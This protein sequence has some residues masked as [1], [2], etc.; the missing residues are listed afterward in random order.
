MNK[1]IKKL[2]IAVD[3]VH[4]FGLK[5]FSVEILPWHFS[6]KY[7]FYSMQLHSPDASTPAPSDFRLT[8]AD[9]S[10]LMQIMAARPHFYTEAQLKKRFQAGHM[11]FLGWIKTEPVHLRWNFVHSVYLPYLKRNLILSDQEVWADEAYTH[12]VHRRSG[13]YAYA[14]NLITRSLAEMN[15]QRLSCTFA[16]WNTF[17]QRIALERG[18]KPMG[19]IVYHNYL[20]H[21]KYSYSGSVQERDGNTIEIGEK[22]YRTRIS[23]SEE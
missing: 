5:K 7:I 6:R 10:D 12:P 13:I 16:S 4:R 19:E 9:E 23:S 11:C 1:M 8:L 3:L 20:V 22:S 17:P 2:S 18:M 21:Y 14:G 15:Y